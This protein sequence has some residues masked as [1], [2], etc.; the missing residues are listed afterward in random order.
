M[1][2]LDEGLAL[3]APAA[4]APVLAGGL[5]AGQPTA[6]PPAVDVA[7]PPMPPA[8]SAKGALGQAIGIM[9]GAK[10]AVGQ[11]PLQAAA[12]KAAQDDA[13]ARAEAAANL[14]AGI[15]QKKALMDTPDPARPA[16][17]RL[18]PLDAAPVPEHK[19][20]LRSFG[21]LLPMIAALGALTTRTPAI[22]ALN[23]ATAMV[24]ATRNNDKVEEEKQRQAWI[25]NTKLTTENN[26]QLLNQ[27]KL[28]L[29]DRN[30]TVTEKMAKINA[31]AALNQDYVTLAALKGGNLDA[32]SKSIALQETATGQLAGL[33]TQLMR[34]QAQQ[35]Q[36]A[37]ERLRQWAGLEI[38]SR[39][40]GNVSMGDS[41]GPLLIKIQSAG[42]KDLSEV[43]TPGERLALQTYM[44]INANLPYSD[45][46]GDAQ[47][48]AGGLGD[49]LTGQ[50]PPPPPGNT[51][52]APPTTSPSQ[53]QIQPAPRDPKA[54][55]V[56]QLYGTPRGPLVWTAGG[57][58]PPA[59]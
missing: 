55:K 51:P 29:D 30:M 39:K 44:R 43:L 8:P 5:P 32:L 46:P 14:Q 10:A 38:Q 37:D 2:A 13:V 54:R 1:S 26:S 36:F 34:D 23:A 41:I 27:Y 42:G 11:D 35:Q 25:D 28:D 47:R 19:D 16:V 50:T 4:A 31:T 58:V 40:A 12:L 3:A 49:A 22:A 53:P 7:P 48:P 57:W 21:Q 6:V 45:T 24:N 18:K 9:R 20:P 59:S 52:P 33:T 17:P 56:G 15:N